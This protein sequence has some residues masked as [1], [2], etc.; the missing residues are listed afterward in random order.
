MREIIFSEEAVVPASPYSQAIVAQGR[1]LY[2]SGQGS[3]DPAT[4]LHA[5]IVIFT[6]STVKNGNGWH[7][8]R[9]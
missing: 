5:G 8:W 1:T 7:P 4:N 9:V 3:F 2:I 6:Y